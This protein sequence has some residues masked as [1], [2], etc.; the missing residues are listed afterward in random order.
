[1]GVYL[2]LLPKQWQTTAD[3]YNALFWLEWV[4]LW[5]FAAAWLTKGRMILADVAIDLLAFTH[6]RLLPGKRNQPKKT[7]SRTVD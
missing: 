5:A 1:M 4:A 3:E 2:F 7:N 6:Q